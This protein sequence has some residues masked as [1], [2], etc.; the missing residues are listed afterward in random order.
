MPDPVKRPPEYADIRNR[1]MEIMAK[2]KWTQAKLTRKLGRDHSW[3]SKIFRPEH[4]MKV[5]T[6]LKICKVMEISPSILFQDITD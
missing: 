5:T 6:I 4:E 3:V 1:L 2:R